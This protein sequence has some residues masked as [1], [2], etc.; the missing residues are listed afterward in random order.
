MTAI[1][2]YTGPFWAGQEIARRQQGRDKSQEPGFLFIKLGHT[3]FLLFVFGSFD[4]GGG[5][6][7]NPNFLGTF[8]I[9]FGYFPKTMGEDDKKPKKN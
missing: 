3:Q 9:R 8:L 2:C 1:L 4:A 5:S 6:Y 7:P